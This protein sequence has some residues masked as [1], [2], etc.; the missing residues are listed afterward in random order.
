[1]LTSKIE[2]RYFNWRP[3][4]FTALLLASKFWDDIGL[5]NIDYVEHLELYGLR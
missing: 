5:W 4:V 1:M 2:I 3:L